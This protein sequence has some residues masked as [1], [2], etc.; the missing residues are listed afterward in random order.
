MARLI[1]SPRAIRDLS[2]ICEYIARDSE[3]YART[4][5]ERVVALAER[6]PDQPVAGSIV[7]EYNRDDLRERF[8]H[9]DRIVYRI[10]G[11][12]VELVTISHGARLLP[13]TPDF[14]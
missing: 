3:H 7:P 11:D 14:D 12:A 9:N 5:P 1:W 13:E 4:F 2:E 8:L 10:R 6:V